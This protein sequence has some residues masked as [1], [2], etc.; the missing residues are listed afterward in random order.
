MVQLKNA[1]MTC[2]RRGESKDVRSCGV[3]VVI[4]GR[5][6]CAVPLVVTAAPFWQIFWG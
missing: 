4:G 1:R 3:S 2:N 6:F 5:Q